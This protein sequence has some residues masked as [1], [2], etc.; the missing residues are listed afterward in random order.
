MRRAIVRVTN[1]LGTDN[2]VHRTCVVL[3]ELGY[4][5]LLVG[6]IL[7]GSLPLGPARTA[8]SACGCSSG[9][10]RCSMR[11]TTCGFSCCCCSRKAELIVANDLDTL[12]ACLSGGAPEGSELVYD[13]HEYFTEVPELLGRAVRRVW[14]AIERWIFPKLEHVITVND[15][16]ADAYR[17]RYGNRPDGGAQHPHAARS[18]PAATPRGNW[19]CPTDRFILILQGSGINVERGAEE[20]VLAMQELPECLLLLVG[21]GDAWPVLERMVKEHGLAGPCAHAAADALRAHDAVHAQRR[22]GPFAGQGHQPELPLQPAQQA[23]RL[24]PAQASRRW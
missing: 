5:V 9:R 6:R 17:D 1:D 21:G 13:S 19:T 22:P 8:P 4:D 3:H 15:S 2:R 23:L 12:L 24:L 14:L 7:P 10:G 11:N 20:A 16:I 18:G